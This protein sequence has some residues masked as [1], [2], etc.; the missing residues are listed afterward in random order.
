M[1]INFRGL[2]FLMENNQNIK[3]INEHKKSDE[4]EKLVFSTTWEDIKYTIIILGIFFIIP[5]IKSKNN[6]DRFAFL[7]TFLFLIFLIIVIYA[8]FGIRKIEFYPDKILLEFPGKRL[9]TIK[10]QDI[11]GLTI[12]YQ[13][14]FILLNRAKSEKVVFIF[15]LNIDLSYLFFRKKLVINNFLFSDTAGGDATLKVVEFLRKHYADLLIDKLSQDIFDKH[16]Q[17]HN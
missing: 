8:T 1:N 11:K 3:N 15:E 4:E 7:A 16:N 14:P 10:K 13:P 6:Y 12:K 2:N 9:R 17:N 5:V